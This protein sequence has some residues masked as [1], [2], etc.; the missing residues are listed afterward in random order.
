M[1]RT[2]CDCGIVYYSGSCPGCR[3]PNLFNQG[4]SSEEITS[5]EDWKEYK[6][7]NEQATSNKS[8]KHSSS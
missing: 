2:K 4:S 5:D 6:R 8:N 3:R 7:I 1:L